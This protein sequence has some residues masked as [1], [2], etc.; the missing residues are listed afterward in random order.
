MQNK[1][2]PI[3]GPI[4]HPRWDIRLLT[5][6]RVSDMA[7][8]TVGGDLKIKLG[9]LLWE[10]L[11]GMIPRS[12]LNVK[13]NMHHIAYLLNTKRDAA[14]IPDNVGR[15]GSISHICDRTGCIKPDYLQATPLHRRN[16]D[17]QRCPG[18]LIIHYLGEIF[19]NPCLHAVDEVTLEE[20]ID[21]SCRK[22][23]FF[24]LKDDEAACVTFQP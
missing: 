14:P 13:F 21:L 11:K 23:S 5:P 22:I 24:E 12:D 19:E 8:G 1:S 3:P 9:P 2:D 10:K 15:G 16:L 20:K 17:R 6:G 7:T 4:N 18:V